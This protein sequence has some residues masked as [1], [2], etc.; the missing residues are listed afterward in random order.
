M[1]ERLLRSLITSSARASTAR[2][3]DIV[4]CGTASSRAI[5]PAANPSGSYFTSIL[6]ALIRVDC[7]RAASAR[8]AC[9]DSIYLDIQIYGATGQANCSMSES[10]LFDITGNTGDTQLRSMPARN[11]DGD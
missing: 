2:C 9:S 3:A 11:Q 10:H 8:I 5:S 4:F 7:A 6:N 1:I